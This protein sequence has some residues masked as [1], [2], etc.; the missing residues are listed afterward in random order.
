MQINTQNSAN[1]RIEIYQRSG[2]DVQMTD[3][4]PNKKRAPQGA[5]R[6][7]RKQ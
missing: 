7:W 5:L 2:S 4:T 1:F 6:A 3:L